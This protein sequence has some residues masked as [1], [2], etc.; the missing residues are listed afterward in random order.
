MREAFALTAGVAGL[1]G[2]DVE[3]WYG[4][5]RHRFRWLG[6]GPGVFGGDVFEVE[7]IRLT[8][9][10]LG[11]RDRIGVRVQRSGVGDVERF[12]LKVDGGSLHRDRSDGNRLSA[13]VDAI[14]NCLQSTIVPRYLH[15][16]SQALASLEGSLPV[17]GDVFF[18]R[19][20]CGCERS[21]D[22]SERG[23]PQ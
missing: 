13:L 5:G 3:F 11:T 8:A 23:H 22:E 14:R 7:Y 2:D 1:D 20:E 15:D 6:D 19:V 4:V 16:D 21:D 10:S 9:L 17:S 18:L 12:N